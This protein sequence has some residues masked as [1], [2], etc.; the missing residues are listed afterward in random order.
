ML[1]KNMSQY[2]SNNFQLSCCTS[3]LK[4]FLTTWLIEFRRPVSQKMN[5]FMC[6]LFLLTLG[7]NSENNFK[8]TL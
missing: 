3:L 8:G 5:A 1:K 4:S 2:D 7:K 6:F